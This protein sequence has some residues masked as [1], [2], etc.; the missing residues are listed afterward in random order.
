MLLPDYLTV[1]SSQVHPNVPFSPLLTSFSPIF[2]G[3]ES[4][5]VY[6]IEKNELCLLDGMEGKSIRLMANHQGFIAL[7]SGMIFFFFYSVINALILDIKRKHSL[8]KIFN[9][10]ARMDEVGN[11]NR[12]SNQTASSDECRSISGH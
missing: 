5:K 7:L 11:S 6:K 3:T 8:C 2:P 4:G 10:A 12:V 1:L 9:H